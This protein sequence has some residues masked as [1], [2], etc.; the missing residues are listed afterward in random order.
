MARYKIHKRLCKFNKMLRRDV[1]FVVTIRDPVN[2][3]K[4]WFDF[5]GK[6]GLI[7]PEVTFSEFLRTDW[8]RFLFVVLV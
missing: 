7:A 4:S 3:V 5:G 1:R 6:K 2:T 8:F